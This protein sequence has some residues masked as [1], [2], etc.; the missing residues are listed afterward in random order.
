MTPNVG[1]DIEQP[2]LSYI[3]RGIQNGANT[4]KRLYDNFL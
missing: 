2:E 1:E 3:G 4:G